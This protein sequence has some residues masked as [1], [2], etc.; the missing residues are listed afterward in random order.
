[1]DLDALR[2]G[3]R[4]IGFRTAYISV[5]FLCWFTMSLVDLILN[6]NDFEKIAQPMIMV[7]GHSIVITIY[8]RFIISRDRFIKLLDDFQSIVDESMYL[9]KLK[10][11]SSH[12]F[13]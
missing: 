1:M 2:R 7:T 13:H 6:I 4:W 8:W 9:S 11:R 10:I 5:S 12:Q 3:E